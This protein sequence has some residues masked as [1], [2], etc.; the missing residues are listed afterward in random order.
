VKCYGP[1]ELKD[2]K[3]GY[4]LLTK[5]LLLSLSIRDLAGDFVR[6]L[7]VEGVV[8]AD[9]VAVKPKMNGM[10]LITYNPFYVWRM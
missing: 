8:G 1:L 9:A 3:A 10:N 5:V 2:K 7:L 6:N 4:T